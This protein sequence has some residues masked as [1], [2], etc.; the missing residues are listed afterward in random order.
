L[1]ITTTALRGCGICR[2]VI[3]SRRAVNTE[4]KLESKSP[5]E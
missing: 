1:S 5:K 3:S 2:S 4:P